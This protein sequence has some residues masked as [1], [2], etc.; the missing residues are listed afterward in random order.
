MRTRGARAAAVVLLLCAA[1]AAG[2][3]AARAQTLPGPAYHELLDRGRDDLAKRLDR[4]LD[5]RTGTDDADV[6][7]L[8]AR[9][10]AA[11][12]GPQTAWEWLAVARA[13]VRAG[14]AGRAAE[15]LERAGPGVPEGLRLLELARIGFLRGAPEAAERWWRACAVAG[16]AAALEAWLDLEPLATPEELEAWDGF[17]RLPALQ[18][19]DCAFFRSFLNRRALASAMPVDARLAEHYARMRHVRERFR[20]RGKEVGTLGRRLDLARR[21]WFDDRGFLYLRLGPP[22]ETAAML[23]DECFETNVTWAYDEPGGRR[24]YHLS[25]AGG[26]DDWWLVENLGGVYRCG[27]K[28]RGSGRNPFVESP[29]LLVLIPAGV[30]RD[31]YMS[32]ASLD[33]TYARSAFRLDKGPLERIKEFQEERDRTFADAGRVIRDV[34]E[35]PAV[36]LEVR[37]RMEWLQFRHPRPH[38]TRVWLNAEV[39]LRDVVSDGR[40]GEDLELAVDVA[41]L[42][43]SGQRMVTGSHRVR[44]EGDSVRRDEDR[45]A[46]FRFPLELA[47]GRW[48]T[49]VTVRVA[50]DRDDPPRGTFL[51]DTLD[52]RDMA[53]RL[54]QLSDIAV[55]PDSGGTWEPVPG[56]RLRPLP[57]HVSGKD[58]SARIF[59][60][61]YNLTPGG[62]F[63]VRVRLDPV[64][65][66]DE[67]D[68]APARPIFR[69]EFTGVAAPGGRVVT[70]IL[71]RLDLAVTPPG[72][73]DLS[74]SVEDRTSGL[75]SLTARTSLEV[76]EAAG[77]G[78]ASPT[79]AD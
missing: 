74:L 50:D 70:P 48:E 78:S 33:P 65:G 34:A 52:V 21:P 19:D 16:E 38:T 14:E 8:L 7:D 40:W 20:R 1:A 49:N 56:I 37:I 28:G 53:G 29:A 57:A 39:P 46:A 42:D 5:P 61:A 69:Q 64:G 25:P 30:L 59:L 73:Y 41:A 26:V 2:P 15:A 76:V 45:A 47:P 79:A 23:G 63:L 18:R 6:Q 67:S 3:A 35:R 68:G 10:R 77:P 36:D 51:R 62:D 43:D 11:E 54:P 27:L 22:D 17:R 55:S 9:W 44:V 4:V 60:E 58:R 13:W 66:G 32:R 24:L 75:R 12:G 72:P 71:L 31:L